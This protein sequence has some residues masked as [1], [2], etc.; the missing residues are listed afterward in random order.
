MSAKVSAMQTQIYELSTKLQNQACNF[1]TNLLDNHPVPQSAADR[2]AQ[3][4]KDKAL[5]TII[6]VRNTTC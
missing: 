2:V 5:K 3:A 4:T 6:N 1:K